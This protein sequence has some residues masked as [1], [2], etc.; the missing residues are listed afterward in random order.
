MILDWG[1]VMKRWLAVCLC[2]AV[3]LFS[4]ADA[5]GVAQAGG[6][7]QWVQSLRQ[8]KFL[9]VEE[10][11]QLALEITGE[12]ELRLQFQIAD[13][14]YLY[15]KRFGFQVED[16]EGAV[17]AAAA[18]GPG[19]V[20]EDE[21]FG[22]SEVYYRAANIALSLARA[23]VGPATLKVAS[24]GCADAGLCY[25]PRQQTFQVDF[26]ANTIAVLAPAPVSAPTT[27]A[28]SVPALPPSLPLIILF[29]FLGGCLLNL[30]PCVFPVLSLKV[31]SFAGGGTHSRRH[32][33]I[34]AAGVVSSFL[35]VAT[36][37]IALQHAGSAVG[38]GFQLQSPRVNALLAY[39]FFALGLALSGVVELGAGFMGAGSRLAERGGGS[40]S[41]FTGVL[42]VVVASPCTA[43]FMGTAV[44]FAA[45]QSAPTAL[46]VFAALGAGMAAPL[47]LLGHSSFLRARM[48]Q[49]GPWMATF[50]QLLAFPLYATAIWLL[51]V[52]GRQTGITPM[53]L[54]LAGMLALA[55]GLWLWA[56]GRVGRAIGIAAIA[57]ALALVASPVLKAPADSARQN[58]AAGMGANI[59]PQEATGNGASETASRAN[60]NQNQNQNQNQNP[61][62][63]PNPNPSEATAGAVGINHLNQLLAAGRPVLV[64]VTADW[65]ITCIVNE[66]STL[67]TAKVQ[68][69]LSE[70]GVAY[71]ALDWTRYDADIA[72]YLAAFGRNGVPLYLFYSG[73]PGTP[74]QILPQLLTPGIV[75]A[76]LDAAPR[77]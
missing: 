35:L 10:A 20:R 19:V 25:P 43:P 41:F 70:R 13:G 42:A 16:A 30:M 77:K 5:A 17:A 3:V 37:L 18:I 73:A 44:G 68:T 54:L 58:G 76:A 21:F 24:Q 48:P 33:W 56:R 11:Y 51:W 57:A 36:V 47:L 67:S 28:P 52:S 74:P 14:Y 32:G 26:A 59:I 39:L 38:W 27:S 60:P 1:R 4:A 64:N 7:K 62:P 69:A 71:L 2:G 50:R 12:R 46:L 31:L 61:N 29:A 66:R 45:T 75:L 65:C 9:P 55:F 22:I 63:N 72:A 40:G 8:P 15:R 6:L 49:P 34:Y 53:A 23:P